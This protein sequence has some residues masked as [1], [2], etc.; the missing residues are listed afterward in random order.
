MEVQVSDLLVIIGE[1]EVSLQMASKEI[2]KLK[3]LIA[4]MEKELNDLRGSQTQVK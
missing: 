1:K 3:A 4:Q 2:S